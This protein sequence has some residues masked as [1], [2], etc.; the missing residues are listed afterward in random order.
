MNTIIHKRQFI[1]ISFKRNVEQSDKR[2]HRIHEDLLKFFAY[3]F[4]NSLEGL[5][6]SFSKND[7]SILEVLNEAAR[8]NE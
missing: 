6:S 4:R 1:I 5:T 2:H 7:L 8:P 3:E